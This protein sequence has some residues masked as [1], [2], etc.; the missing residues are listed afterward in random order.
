VEIKTNNREQ[1]N[2][3]TMNKVINVQGSE[4]ALKLGPLAEP[5]VGS[6]EGQAVLLPGPFPLNQVNENIN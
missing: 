6:E 5:Q 2:I 3:W 1:T 4:N